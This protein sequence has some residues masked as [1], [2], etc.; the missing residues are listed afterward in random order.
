M[1]DQMERIKAEHQ[2]L[3]QIPGSSP[4]DHRQRGVAVKALL[5]LV[6]FALGGGGGYMLGRQS[7]HVGAPTTEA[8]TQQDAM[9]LMKEVNPPEG[10]KVA[11]VFGEV[12]PQ[13]VAAGAIDMIKFTSLYKEQN[14]PL[15]EDQKNI[16]T[17][18]THADIVFTPSNAYFL[19]NFFWALGLTNQNAILTD[20]PMMSGGKEKVGGFASTGGWNSRRQR[21]HRAICQHQNHVVN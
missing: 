18:G 13:L 8:F 4:A 17:K 11:A 19:L 3:D 2:P 12:G 7:M 21:C 20:G 16:L 5:L 6:V 1:S 10:Y 14:Q 15:T 9:A